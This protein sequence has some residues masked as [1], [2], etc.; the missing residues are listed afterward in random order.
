MAAEVAAGVAEV[1]ADT[2]P[3]E[4]AGAEMVA[5]A[6]IVAVWTVC[7]VLYKDTPAVKIL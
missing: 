5:S 1:V 7:K 2:A 3:A 4:V 6:V